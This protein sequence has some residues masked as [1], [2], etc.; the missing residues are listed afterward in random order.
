M[1]KATSILLAILLMFSSLFVT[2]AFADSIPV[3]VTYQ[4]HVRSI[5]WQ[6]SV[7][8]GEAAGTEGLALRLEA[9]KINLSNA[10]A[11]ASIKYE[12]HV[13]HIG[14]QSWV[15]D[16]QE[17]G[18]VGR[19]LQVEAI[20]ISLENMPGY[21]VEYQAHVSNIGWQP[22]VSDG[23]AAG[24][25]G[26]SLQIEAIKIR[27]VSV[28]AAVVAPTITPNTTSPTKNNVTV[29]ITAETNSTIQYSLDSG[30][31]WNN[32][33]AP[34][35]ITANTMII[36]KATDLAG[37]TSTN[38]MTISNIDKTAP[39]IFGVQNGG[40]YNNS[41]TITFNEGT[42]TLNGNAFTSASTVFN[43]GE[44]TLIVI[45]KTENITIDVFTID[46][47]A[48]I[49]NGVSNGAY[50]NV[51]RTITFNEGTAT[52]NGVSFASGSVAL[53]AGKNTLIMTDKAGNSSSITF[54]MLVNVKYTPYNLSLS[55]MASD[56]HVTASQID[57]SIILANSAD[58]YEFLSLRWVDGILA[59]DL[60][61]MLRGRGVLEDHEQDFL[62]AANT[63]N[64]NPVYLIA[65][66]RIETGNGT[67]T[68]SKGVS[69]SAGT[70]TDSQKHTYVITT[71]DT[72]YNFFGIRAYDGPAAVADAS[73]FAASKN[74]NSITAAIYGGAQWLS[75]N[76]ISSAA[77]FPTGYDQPTLY[78]MQ[79]DPYGW[80]VKGYGFEYATGGSWAESIAGIISQYSDIFDGKTL[81]YDI[82]QYN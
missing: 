56:N 16:G 82:P 60:K 55:T 32:Y 35:T 69:I 79:Y 51:S 24:T 62:A 2:K 13:A 28:T 1:K 59:S 30:A 20:K 66:A 25:T 57:P 54:T 76:Y 49:V 6:G 34:V 52:L 4:S 45:D 80:A 22:W 29:T 26:R 48:P 75:V 47:T 73:L 63:Y 21:S 10:P 7:S 61:A 53:N 11:G 39:T 3:G 77:H 74:W 58:A 43:E 40:N 15:S 70:Y 64:I 41:K 23:Q 42:A 14:W 18:T 78:Q 36:A 31:T 67:S 50:Y 68:L 65:H 8:N 37:N 9:L 17:A 44:Y 71:S 72:Y 27:I 19:A 38:D 81:S 33:T 12:A 5:G 46:K